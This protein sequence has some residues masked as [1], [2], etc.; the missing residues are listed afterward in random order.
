MP[1][2][3]LNSLGIE[4]TRLIGAPLGGALM[5]LMGL[6]SVVVL[7][8]VSFMVS[9]L[10]IGLI[11]A[12]RGGL[13]APA[14]AP[15]VGITALLAGIWRDLVEGLQLVRSTRWLAGLFLAMGVLMFGQGITNALLA[16]FVEQ[17]LHGDAQVFGWIVTA[18]GI[19]GLIGGLLAGTIGRLFSPVRIMA[20]S[21]CTMGVLVLL[22]V[23]IPVLPVVLALV[24][25]IGL[26][27]VAF[28]VSEATMLQSGVADQY[29]GR[30]L[31]SYGMALALAMLIGMG[32]AS[33][34]GDWLGA[35]PL[36][37]FVSGLYVLTGV[38]VLVLVGGYQPATA[39]APALS[40]EPAP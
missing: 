21:A 28:M 16:P 19:G 3:S 33:A 31:G 36:L 15:S 22:I 38:I 27:V 1:A 10:L 37:D 34:L 23:N 35:V 6:A 12:P 39:D 26:P 24:A 17:V 11:A 25:V 7:D 32:V 8:C 2:N 5:A 30:V 9:A 40:G 14:V 29:R 4:L 20:V 18:Q 13:A